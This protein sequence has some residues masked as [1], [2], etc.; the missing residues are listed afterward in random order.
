MRLFR[1]RLL[2]TVF[3]LD[4]VA[5]ADVDDADYDLTLSAYFC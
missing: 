3:P 4:L 2:G 1:G 5:G